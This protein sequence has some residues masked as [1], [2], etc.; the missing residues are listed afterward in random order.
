MPIQ[1]TYDPEQDILL[2]KADGHVSFEDI[3]THLDQEIA[4]RAERH[5]EL[6]DATGASTD[7]TS[8]EVKQ[9]VSRLGQM[10]KRGPFGPT[11]VIATND[12]FFGM[13]RMLA[14]LSE[15]TGGPKVE[16]FRSV[17]EG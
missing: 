9:L 2:T 13:A 8:D 14:I 16:V 4:A 12:M 3:Q 15:L 17:Q 6:F 7:L 11:A 10:M 5:R 1:S